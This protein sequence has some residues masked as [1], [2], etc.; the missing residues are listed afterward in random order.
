MIGA[1]DHHDVHVMDDAGALLAKRRLLEGLEG[2]RR[3]HE[4]IGEFV[5]D[6][7]EVV[8]GIETNRGLWVQA[9]VAGG[10]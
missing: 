5:D 9:L 10:Y 6:P 3:L 7:G 8:V 4:L 1:E 2:I